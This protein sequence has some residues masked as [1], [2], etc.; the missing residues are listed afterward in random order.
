MRQGI[1]MNSYLLTLLA[2]WLHIVPVIVALGGA[3]FVR[4]VLWPASGEALDVESRAQLQNS[5]RRRW[6]RFVHVCIALILLSGIYNLASTVAEKPP[7]YLLLMGF[8]LVAAVGVFFLA[9]ALVGSSPAFEPLRAAAPKWMAVLVYLGL[10]IVLLSGLLR[11]T[12]G[13]YDSDATR[14]NAV[15]TTNGTRRTPVGQDKAQVRGDFP[16]RTP[17]Y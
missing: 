11:Q 3:V 15:D 4:F 16:E 9:S 12:T 6:K 1:E 17:R 13:P 7:I 8:K 5:I 14:V 10:V 2:R